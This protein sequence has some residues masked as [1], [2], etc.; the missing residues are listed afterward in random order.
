MPKTSCFQILSTFKK[1]ELREFSR[2]VYSPFFN[3]RRETAV[4][5]KAIKKFYPEFNSKNF[6][7]EKIFAAVY[8]TKEYDIRIIR[9]LNSYLLKLIELYLSYKGLKSDMFYFDLSLAIQYSERGLYGQSQKQ[10]EFTDKKYSDSKGDYEFYFWKRYLIE[11]HKNSLYSYTKNDHLA[12]EAILKRTDMFSYHS[13]VIICKGLI[14]LF[15]NS[16]NFNTDFTGGDFYCLVKN[17]NLENYIKNL[18]ETN[19][20]FYS[21][22]AAEYYQAM[23]LLN[24]R[25]DNFFIKFKEVLS[26]DMNMFSYIERINLYT[27]FEAVCTLKIENGEHSYS[28]DLF[29]AYKRMLEQGLYSYSPG[30]GFILRIFRNI[31]HTAIMEKETIWLEKFLEKYLSKLPDDSR[32]GMSSLANALLLFEDKKFNE[33]LGELNKIN[34]DLFH[35]KIDIKNLQV[36]LYYELGYTEETLSLI[37]SYRHFISG[38]KYISSRYKLICSGFVNSVNRLIKLKTHADD[39]EK[40][41]L[42]KEI[43]Q[44]NDKINQRWLLEKLNELR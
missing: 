37:D 14:S 5:F 27:I 21:V 20:E 3:G 33:S 42:R 12:S 26:L 24:P 10:L 22:L 34:Y 43:N 23:S 16:K 4:Y 9:R 32:K 25:D 44:I 15:I 13:A 29:E 36:K 31:V 30:G 17:L 18:N 35:Y 1:V 38:N 40:L 39:G 11:R 2:F 28:K 8:P 19:N 41:L 6:T 7:N